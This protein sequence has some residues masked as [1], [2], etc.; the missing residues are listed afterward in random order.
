MAGSRVS[1]VTAEDPAAVELLEAAA[2]V[3]GSPGHR[4]SSSIVHG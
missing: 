1:K 4:R 3:Q 2:L